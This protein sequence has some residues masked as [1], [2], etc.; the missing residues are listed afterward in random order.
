MEVSP[1]YSL[2]GLILRLQFFGHLMRRASSL[3]K[4]LMLGK[5]LAGGEGDTEDQMVGWHHRLHGHAFEQ[6]L[7]NSGGQRSL[8]CCSPWSCKESDTI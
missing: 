2:E 8:A 3:A 1:E 7:G 4:T 5:M 6:S